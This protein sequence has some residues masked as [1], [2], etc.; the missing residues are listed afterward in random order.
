MLDGETTSISTF[1]P[2][3]DRSIYIYITRFSYNYLKF[4]Y[5]KNVSPT[6]IKNKL[7]INILSLQKGIIHWDDRINFC[8][9]LKHWQLVNPSINH[10]FVPFPNSVQK[11]F[12]L[13][14]QASMGF[15]FFFLQ[16]SDFKQLFKDEK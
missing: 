6:S 11:K 12:S 9:K 10:C 14:I 15:F 13:P 8:T 16:K 7:L 4:K 3:I 2:Q 1:G 5:N